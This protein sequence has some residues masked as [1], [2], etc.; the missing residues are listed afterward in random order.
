MLDV[1]L[2]GVIVDQNVIK[3]HDIELVQEFVED[4]IDVGLK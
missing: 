3:V 2:I 4:V 1:L